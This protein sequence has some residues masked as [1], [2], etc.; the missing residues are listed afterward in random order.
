MYKL[1]PT[2]IFMLVCVNIYSQ[3]KVNEQIL[4]NIDSKKITV[5]EFKRIYTKN[6]ENPKYDEASLNDYMELFVNFKLKVIE[7]EKQGFDTTKTFKNELKK[8]RIQLEKPYLT[9]KKA[10]D[11]LIKEAYQRMKWNIAA[12]HILISCAE[13]S[14]PK[15]TL[16]AY[17]KIKNIRKQ[18]IQKNADFGSLAK[19]YSNDPSAKQ[20]KGYLGYFSVFSMVY[21]FES[22]AYN[23]KVGQVSKIIKTRFG[24]HIIKVKDKKI[25]E[26]QIK[27]AHLMRAVPVDSDSVK[28]IEEK[29]KIHKIYDSIMQGGDFIYFVKKYSDDKGTSTNGGGLPYFGVGRMIPE[30]EQAA[31]GIKTIGNYSKPVKTNYGWHIIKLLDKKP[32]GSFEE[33]KPHLKN[34]I[35][36]G[37]RAKQGQKR[38]IEKLKTEYKFAEQKNNIKD[39]NNIVDESIYKGEW[40]CLNLN[41]M[42]KTLFTIADTIYTQAD[43]CNY[44]SENGKYYPK[45]MPLS[46]LVDKAYK[47]YVDDEIIKF[48]QKNLENKYPEF[49]YLL[50]EYHDGILLFNISDKKIWTKAIT[51]TLGF[52][53]FYENNKN[54]YLWG[55]R[56]EATVYVFNNKKYESKIKKIA[57]KT[58]KKN[59]DPAVDIK[60]LIDKIQKKDTAFILQ[61][62]KKKY[63]KG[64]NKLIDKLKNTKG[65]KSA[66]EENGKIKLVYING[67]VPPEPKQIEQVK[68]LVTADYQNHLEKEWIKHLREKY[69]IKIDKS[70]FEKMIKK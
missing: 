69:T 40:K 2:L 15:D 63:S 5:D 30:F 61:V 41:K 53:K 38:L 27:V 29:E 54:N 48:E 31:F 34:R 20:N 65:I 56:T 51:D 25:N 43:F 28:K 47:K 46:I 50:K 39:I 3:N 24:Y 18:A 70:V 26:G 33:L 58:G 57:E 6:N 42:Q 13:N 1:F 23:T 14:L 67:E 66:I 44:L 32:I 37:L 62:T 10:D 19:K 11:E 8:Y 49:K 21:P 4:L 17:N 9:D 22:A 60:K 59:T 7:A 36:K 55:K 52:M 45:K 35:S 16:E 12:S 68:G 64:E